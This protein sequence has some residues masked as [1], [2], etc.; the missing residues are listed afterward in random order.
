V[1]DLT[2]TSLGDTLSDDGDR[3]DLRELHELHCG[4]ENGTGRS[5]VDDSVDVGVLCHGVGSGLVD[6]EEGLSGAPVPV[7]LSIGC[8]AISG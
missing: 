6:R 2:C 4:L 3:L 8:S 1:K 5:E 7:N